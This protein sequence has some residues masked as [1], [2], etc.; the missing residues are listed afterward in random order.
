MRIMAGGKNY[1]INRLVCEAFHGPPPNS[2]SQANHIDK[3]TKNNRAD[4]LEW[5]TPKENVE[6]SVARRVTQYSLEGIILFEFNSVKTVSDMIGITTCQICKLCNSTKISNKQ[7][8][9][10]RYSEDSFDEIRSKPDIRSG[11]QV[12]KMSL[13]GEEIARYKGVAD[14]LRMLNV[15]GCRELIKHAY[16]NTEYKGFLWKIIE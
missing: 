14:T 3:N 1:S 15:S 8:Y 13:D 5:M 10:F 6:Y 9:V 4:N 11:K 7:K 2:K 16:N 12:V